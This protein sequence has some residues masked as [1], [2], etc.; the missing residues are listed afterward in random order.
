[1]TRVAC[2]ASHRL[3]GKSFVEKSYVKSVI[4]GL[5]VAHVCLAIAAVGALATV[6]TVGW[7]QRPFL[8]AWVP[9]IFIAV[10][11]IV[12][13]MLLYK[14]MAAKQREHQKQH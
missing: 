4:A 5:T 1:M 2:L 3:V 12:T 6:I 10:F 11:L 9:V 8:V 13:L 7:T 14:D